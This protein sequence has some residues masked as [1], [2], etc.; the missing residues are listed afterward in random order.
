[1]ITS[2]TSKLQFAGDAST[3][4][5]AFPYFFL[6]NAHIQVWSTT[7]FIDTLL[8]ETVGYNVTGA[9]NPA[10]GTVTMTVAAEVGTRITI[11]RVV[12]VTQIVDYVPNDAFPA[13]SHENALDRLTMVCQM[14][15]EMQSRCIQFS[16]GEASTLSAVLPQ[17]DRANKALTFDSLGQLRLT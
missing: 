12:P 14:L 16:D 15:V 1:M 7:E 2:T 13:A 10:G 9:A 11:K 3:T 6:L 4:V 17:Q 8:V 5:Y